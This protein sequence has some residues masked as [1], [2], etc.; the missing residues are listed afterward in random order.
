MLFSGTYSCWLV[1]SISTAWRWLNV[2]RWQSSPD[3][4][5]R[6]PSSSSEPNASAS[7]VAQSMPCPVSSIACLA[8]SWRAMRGCT[9]NPAGTRDSAMPI[10]FSVASGTAVAAS[11]NSNSGSGGWKPAQWPSSQSALFGLYACAAWLASSMVRAKSSHI[12]LASSAGT[13]PSAGQPLGI[14]RARGLLLADG[15]I[16]QRLGEGRLVGLV[17]AMAAVADDVQHD[18]AWRSAC[19]TP[20]PCGRRTSPLRGRRR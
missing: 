4:R 14:Q 9:S 8:S 2:P 7:P 13:T 10:C 15:A 18:V 16:H 17:V 6:L 19:G 20:P 1:W 5:T 3:S 11:W 12:A